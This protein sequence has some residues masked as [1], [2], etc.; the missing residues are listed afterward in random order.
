MAAKMRRLHRCAAMVFLAA[1]ILITGCGEKPKPELTETDTRVRRTTL[2]ITS[3]TN[4]WT[5]GIIDTPNFLDQ[6]AVLRDVRIG[7]HEDWDRIVFEFEGDQF[8][9]YHLE[10]IDRPIRKCGSGEVVE[11]DGPGWLQV[12]FY[13][14]QAHT[15]AGNATVTDRQRSPDLPILDE[16]VLVCDFEGVVEWVLGLNNPNRYRVLELADPTRLVV[17]ITH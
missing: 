16:A 10:Y 7:K 11:I 13:P 6:P 17:D 15:R 1:A 9:G 3:D 14:A 5:A 2:S 12:H 4:R 8:P